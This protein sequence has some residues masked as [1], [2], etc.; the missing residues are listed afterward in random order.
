MFCVAVPATLVAGV[1][2]ERRQHAQQQEA[3]AKGQTLKRTRL[4][5]RPVSLG[6]AG[7]LICASILYHSRLP[8]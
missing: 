4:P 8:F 3:Q 6:L 1:S 5:A 2:V 7:L